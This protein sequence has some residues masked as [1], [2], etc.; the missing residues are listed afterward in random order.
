M[1]LDLRAVACWSGIAGAACC[2][3]AAVLSG[4]QFSEYSHISNYL[5]EGFALG[6]PYGRELRFCL[7]APAGLLIALCA[8][9]AIRQVPAGVLGTIGLSCLGLYGLECAFSSVFF[10]CELGCSRGSDDPSLSQSIHEASGMLGLVAATQGMLLTGISARKWQNGAL[11]SVSGIVAAVTG[12]VIGNLLQADPLSAVAGLYQRII[13]GSI[14][15][16]IV[17]LAVHLKRTGSPGDGQRVSRAARS[18][19]L[20]GCRVFAFADFAQRIGTRRPARLDVFLG[21]SIEI[22]ATEGKL[23]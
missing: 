9:L 4:C 11:V 13:E 12:I 17:L 10:P 5:S 7:L 6:T 3:T 19:R 2:M 16:W 23:R 22:E 15:S 21:H 1:K 18:A 8:F 20:A 14:L